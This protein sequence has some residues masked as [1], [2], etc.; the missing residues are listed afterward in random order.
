M[1]LNRQVLETIIQ[2]VP[3]FRAR[4]DAFLKEWQSEDT[5]WYLGMGDLAHYVVET[6]ERGNVDE[7]DNLFRAVEAGL[8]T[9]DETLKELIA[10]GLFEDIQ[11]IASHRACGSSVFRRWLGPRS[12]AVWDE[13]DLGMKR[14]AASA[15]QRTPRWWQFWRRHSGFD[16]ERALSTV[17]SPELRKIIEQMYRKPE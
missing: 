10:I 16:A 9:D 4:W 15:V 1:L 11:N 12:I 8:Q 7:F 5:P 17:E 14:V 2:A 13:V 3:G 6:Y